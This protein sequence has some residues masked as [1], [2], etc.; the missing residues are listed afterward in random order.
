MEVAKD[1]SK[2]TVERTMAASG[3]QTALSHQ[4]SSSQ[5]VGGVSEKLQK[6]QQQKMFSKLAE[7]EQSFFSNMAGF[8]DS[9]HD[10]YNF[11][12]EKIE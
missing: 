6:I 11:S 5:G 4:S 3:S 2:K 7:E 9:Y 12:K 8:V 1:F 10:I